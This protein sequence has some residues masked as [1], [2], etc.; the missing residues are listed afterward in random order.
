MP[1]LQQGFRHEPERNHVVLQ[2]WLS[3]AKAL[4]GVQEKAEKGA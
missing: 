1:V 4:P 3:A 2:H